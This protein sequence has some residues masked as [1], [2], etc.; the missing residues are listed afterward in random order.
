MTKKPRIMVTLEREDYDL[1]KRVAEAQDM[2]MS[3]LLRDYVEMSRPMLTHMVELVEALEKA[4]DERRGIHMAAVEG[5][6][7][8]GQQL[9]DFASGQLPL[10]FDWLQTFAQAINGNETKVSELLG[11]GAVVDTTPISNNMGVRS[12][13]LALVETRREKRKRERKEEKKGGGSAL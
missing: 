3:A 1:V 2:S 9:A 11:E 7:E 4:A 8:K 10:A 5:A 13:D 12:E 6:M